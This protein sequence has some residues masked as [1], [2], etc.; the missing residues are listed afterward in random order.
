MTSASSSHV[1]QVQNIVSVKRVQLFNY[2]GSKCI[3]IN[4]IIVFWVV[5][6]RNP[7]PL[8]YQPGSYLLS[9]AV[10]SKYQASEW[11]TICLTPPI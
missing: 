4:I 8:W 10:I 6:E 7:S 9:I 5:V 1:C 3:V 11:H 2:I